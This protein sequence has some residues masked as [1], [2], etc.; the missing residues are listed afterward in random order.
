MHPYEHIASVALC[1]PL[2]GLHS[3]YLLPP[4]GLRTR[5]GEDHDIP[6]FP[7][8]QAPF[9]IFPHRGGTARTAATELRFGLGG[10]D[11][12]EFADQFEHAG[13]KHPGTDGHDTNHLFESRDVGD[14][15]G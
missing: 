8:L 3:P 10:L 6:T 12:V 5:S 2:W 11:S 15:L 13:G 14:R 1:K 7:H 4:G 9:T